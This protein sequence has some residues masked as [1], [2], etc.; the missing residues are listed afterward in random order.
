[1]KLAINFSIPGQLRQSASMPFFATFHRSFAIAAV[2]AMDRCPGDISKPFIQNLKEMTG[3]NLADNL[4]KLR[5]C[6]ARKETF[7]AIK[8]FK[9]M[10]V[11][12]T[13][14]FPGL[15]DFARSL[16]EELPFYDETY[17]GD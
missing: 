1:V 8:T 10:N 17:G 4:R 13:V 5:L 11:S 16:G 15:D 12:S 9:R 14:L 7:E 3:C 6:F 2:S